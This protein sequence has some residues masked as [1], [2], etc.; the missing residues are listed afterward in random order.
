[1]AWSYALKQR[2]ALYIPK[3][4]RPWVFFNP[5]AKNT[6][7]ALHNGSRL[8]FPG[9]EAGISLGDDPHFQY[10]HGPAHSKRFIGER[11][12]KI[13]KTF[14]TEQID[15]K[16]TTHYIVY[17]CKLGFVGT[18]MLFKNFL[19]KVQKVSVIKP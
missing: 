17:R 14:R 19:I 9:Y 3:G 7:T 13:T 5:S 8:L 15:D 6:E 1:M 12:R 16:K 18:P 2:N 10:F 11:G 4:F